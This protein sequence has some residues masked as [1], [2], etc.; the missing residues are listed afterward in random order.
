MNKKRL[1]FSVLFTLFLFFIDE[2]H[3]DLTSFKS[4]ENWI[5]FFPYVAV[6]YL[7]FSV[8]NKGWSFILGFFQDSKSH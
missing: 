8:I 6:I 7:L 2:G 4:L 1:A 3:Y 5:T